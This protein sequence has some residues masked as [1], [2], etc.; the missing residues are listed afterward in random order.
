MRAL[1]SALLLTA[2]QTYI[3]LGVHHGASGE[4]LLGA[5]Y[6]GL[7]LIELWRVLVKVHR[8]F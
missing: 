8:S 2:G 3:D 5:C 4:I 7:G 1:Q 6:V